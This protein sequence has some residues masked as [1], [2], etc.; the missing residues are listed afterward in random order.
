MKEWT[1]KQQTWRTCFFKF[2]VFSMVTM[3]KDLHLNAG[4]VKY[5]NKHRVHI[6]FA[7][8]LAK[9]MDDPCS[10]FRL[11][12]NIGG[13]DKKQKKHYEVEYIRENYHSL[14]RYEK[15]SFIFYPS[16]FIFILH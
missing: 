4:T 12:F 11:L 14:I 7:G 10:V 13:A 1:A 16:S 6:I 5:H 15:Y 9:I 8:S 2:S 3:E